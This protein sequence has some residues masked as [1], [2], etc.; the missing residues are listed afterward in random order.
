MLSLVV[1]FVA[2]FDDD[3]VLLLVIIRF[4]RSLIIVRGKSRGVFFTLLLLEQICR[5]GDWFARKRGRFVH[6]DEGEQEREEEEDEMESRTTVVLRRLRRRSLHV[7][8]FT[9]MR[10]RGSSFISFFLKNFIFRVP[11]N[12]K[13][14]N[15]FKQAPKHELK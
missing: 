14:L 7:L 5:L 11:R 13:T 6:E 2:H 15:H 3:D 12:L 9:K 8:C 4:S 1:F 10:E